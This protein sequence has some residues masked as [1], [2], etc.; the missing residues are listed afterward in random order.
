MQ[1]K[2]VKLSQIRENDANPRTITDSKFK[3]LIGSLLV[4]PK[5]LEIRPIVVDNTMT[6]LGGN[7][8]CRALCAIADMDEQEVRYSLEKQK[9]FTEKTQAERDAL[10][11]Y[12]TAWKEA[13]TAVVINA[14]DL[15]D[16]E[17]REFI[18]KDN[19]GFG[20]WDFD[21]LA[22]EWD[23]T[24]LTDWGLDVWDD[25]KWK[26]AIGE[27]AEASEDNYSEQEAAIAQIRCN[28]G[29]IWR[30]GEHRLMCGDST[31]ADDVARLMDCKLADLLV[32]DP[33]YNVNYE[34]KTKDALRIDNDNL[35]DAAFIDFLRSAFKC[36]FQSMRAGAAFY[37]WHAD[38][39]GLDFRAALRDN[40]F[41][42]R[43]TLIWVKNV[44]VMGRQDYHWRHEPC[45]YGW[46]DGA[47]H[48][49][50]DDRTQD[51]VYEDV[52][53]DYRKMKKEELLQ[54]VLQMTDVSVPNTV[55]YEDKPLANSI[56]PT[57]KPVKL[58][59]R[60]IK[61]SSKPEQLVLDLFGGS[62][63]TLIACE[64]LGRKC[65]MMEHDPKYCDAII[66]RWEKLT[67]LKA[68][69]VTGG[70]DE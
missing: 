1:T 69:L 28:K 31:N 52:G 26:E 17:K 39:K 22:N 21:A 48:Y 61:N 19:A 51:T 70:S 53:V 13:P 56:H 2:I 20:E 62:G 60:L 16:A 55:I 45:L 42:L 15:T 58:M 41:T 57:M 10:I 37:I 29:D 25:E 23:A 43:E 3:K 7:M 59:A 8:R 34:G 66:D 46:K 50:I 30:L 24:E 14:A 63:S 33:P 18:I 47:A 9:T 4:L 32:T 6:I 35:D 68:E 38:S 40:G 36:A 54:V 12:W 27:D 49:F 64:Q 11:D 5:M 65:C 67:G 44:F